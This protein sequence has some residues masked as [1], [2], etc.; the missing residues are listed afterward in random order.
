MVFLSQQKTRRSKTPG[1]PERPTSTTD[2]RPVA[3]A[4]AEALL[5]VV[6][7]RFV[8]ESA[9]VMLNCRGPMA[10]RHPAIRW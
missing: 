9:A 8:T 6:L 7:Q 3:A 4:A 10:S 2:R 5:A 1:P